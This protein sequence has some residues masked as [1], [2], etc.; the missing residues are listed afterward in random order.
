VLNKVPDADTLHFLRQCLLELEINV[1]ACI[2]DD[3]EL[4][5]AW[6]K[7]SPLYSHTAEA[8]AAKIVHALEERSGA[9]E[10]A[11]PAGSEATSRSH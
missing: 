4:R 2:P 3:P 5:E 9:F 7:G 11:R 6:L 1:A 10:K 8:E